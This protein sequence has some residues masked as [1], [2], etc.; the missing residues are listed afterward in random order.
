MEDKV[1]GQAED[2]VA[3]ALAHFGE[4]LCLDEVIEGE[5]GEHGAVSVDI[6][7][8]KQ[9][10]AS[11][12]V[13]GH[14][15]VDVACLVV[16]MS[17]EGSVGNYFLVAL[18]DDL[19]VGHGGGQAEALVGLCP[20]VEV[21]GPDGLLVF[22]L[23]EV[24]LVAVCCEDR[25]VVAG[26][27]LDERSWGLDDVCVEPEHPGGE[28]TDGGEE[29][30]VSGGGH[31]GASFFL[32]LEGVSVLLE[33]GDGGVVVLPEDCDFGELGRGGVLGALD[34]LDGGLQALERGVSLGCPREDEAKLDE[35][36]W[37]GQLEQV[38]PVVV[39]EVGHGRQDEHLFVVLQR[40]L[41]RLQRVEVVVGDVVGRE[42]FRGPCVLAPRL[43]LV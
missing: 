38:L 27:V 16:E 31:L 32:D 29:E 1:V 42:V 12:T 7:L 40:V 4:A 17:H 6:G 28:G 35:L 9:T 25:L 24:A 36:S 26:H 3:Q 14:F 21:V 15:V 30:G 19:V 18:D 10:S 43:G 2:L 20:V 34:L 8:D 13:E 5:V 22:V 23:V 41:R 33:L 11:D 37:V 39:V